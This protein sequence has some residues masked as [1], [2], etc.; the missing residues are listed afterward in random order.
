MGIVT[1]YYLK[2]GLN[3]TSKLNYKMSETWTDNRAKEAL[4]ALQHF[5]FQEG[6]HLETDD[7]VYEVIEK[8]PVQTLISD[9][10]FYTADRLF[11]NP[12]GEL[13]RSYNTETIKGGQIK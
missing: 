9:D 8:Q 4:E 12:D 7:G 6:E 10:E 5:R 11:E 1:D 3:K 2:A 13:R